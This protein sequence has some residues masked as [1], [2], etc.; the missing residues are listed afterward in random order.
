MKAS[1]FPSADTDGQLFS[2]TESVS[3]SGGPVACALL[4]S[5]GKRHMFTF[6]VPLE[7]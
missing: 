2:A 7:K 6:C 3:R 1:R 4:A 5:M